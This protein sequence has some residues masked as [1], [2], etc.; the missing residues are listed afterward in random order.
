MS[1]ALTL[2]HP[3]ILV[4]VP[5]CPQHII[6]RA[7]LQTTR[8]FCEKTLSWIEKHAN[9]SSVA[10]DGTDIAFVASSP[11]TITSTSTDLSV[12]TAAQ[13]INTSSSE[14]PGPFTLAS[15][16]ENLLTLVAGDTLT[17]ED[18][19]ASVYIGAATYALTSTNGDIV[20][21]DKVKY[22]HIDIGP[23]S[24]FALNSIASNWET[25]MAETPST[26]LM[27][28]D[29]YLR[30]VYCPN[31]ALTGG[32]EAWVC[33]KP[34]LTATTLENYLYTDF[35][36]CIADGA[37]HRLLKMPKQTWTDLKLSAF[38]GQEY[39]RKRS[40]AG[41]KKYDGYVQRPMKVRMRAF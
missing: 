23:I 11:A 40:I 41:N 10:V 16:A 18:A 6:T 38:Y 28:Q 32:I 2:W 27:N 5:G 9:I 25:L 31:T 21:V 24:E 30:L 39:D 33:L 8:D 1:K 15:A 7:V 4:D 3:E 37:R 34:L 35:F 13:V 17:A 12:F 22:D 26:Y 36:E 14:N 20:A 29:R 19:G